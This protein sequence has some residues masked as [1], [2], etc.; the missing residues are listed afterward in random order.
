MSDRSNRFAAAW[1]LLALGALI[2][3]P[4]SIVAAA[5]SHRSQRCGGR[6]AARDWH[7]RTVIQQVSTATTTANGTQPSQVPSGSVDHHSR[8]GAGDKRLLAWFLPDSASAISLDG[9]LRP[10]RTWDA[11][12]SA[13]RTAAAAN[14]PPAVSCALADQRQCHRS[15]DRYLPCHHLPR[16]CRLGPEDG[17]V[18][19]GLGWIEVHGEGEVVLASMAVSPSTASTAAR[20]LSTRLRRMC[21]TLLSFTLPRGSSLK[22]ET[23]GSLHPT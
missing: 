6:L 11:G 7:H 10:R 22:R 8:T 15:L 16:K 18:D 17:V 4:G 9:R 5:Q 14:E 20:P 13:S 2:A 21:T 23:G 19:W 12:H 1:I 3:S